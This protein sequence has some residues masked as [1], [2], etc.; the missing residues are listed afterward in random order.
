MP[1]SQTNKTAYTHSTASAVD[2]MRQNRF[3]LS[4]AEG[5]RRDCRRRS[6]PLTAWRVRLAVICTERVHG[7]TFHTSS[8]LPGKAC[9]SCHTACL[10]FCA[11]SL[12]GCCQ[13][14]AVTAS[15]WWMVY[16]TASIT[17]THTESQQRGKATGAL[18]SSP[19]GEPRRQGSRLDGGSAGAAARADTGRRRRGRVLNLSIFSR[20]PFSRADGR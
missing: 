2:H 10:V 3:T 1:R 18:P 5:G 14:L 6:N 12:G 16:Y 8:E 20:R 15:G 9:L 7:S 4:I 19:A 11:H 17:L 13:Q